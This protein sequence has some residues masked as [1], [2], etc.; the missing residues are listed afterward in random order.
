MVW[1]LDVLLALACLGAFLVGIVL[2]LSFFRARR[3]NCPNHVLFHSHEGFHVAPTRLR[4][5]QFARRLQETHPAYRCDVL[6]YWDHIFKFPGLPDRHPFKVE[7]AAAIIR[8]FFRMW[9]HRIGLVIDQR[10]NYHTWAT[11]LY[12]LASGATVWLDIDDWIFEHYAYLPPLRIRWLLP[13]FCHLADGC[14]VASTPI[15]KLIERYFPA[16]LL[17]PTFVDER[18]F[19]DRSFPSESAVIRFAWI[20]TVFDEDS[21][22]NV[23]FVLQSFQAALPQI[24]HPVVLECL[25]GYNP[26]GTIG[27]DQMQEML[28][29]QFPTLPVRIGDWIQPDAVPAYL[30]T[31]HVGLYALVNPNDFQRSKSPT[32]LFEYMAAGRPVIATAVGEAPCFIRH[33]LDGFVAHSADEFRDAIIRFAND[34][35]AIAAMG[36]QARQ[37]IEAEFN[38]GRVAE[39]LNANLLNRTGIPSPTTGR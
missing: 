6:A 36:V 23:R 16:P 10:P 7:L 33:G 20:G 22:T 12:R 11:V 26:L 3:R 8:S 30:G 18:L 9:T 35:G 38:L 5:Y 21:L 17:I 29:A 4:C 1:P 2:P 15:Q 14:I 31:I 13:I 19:T 37:R 27:R 39:L 25:I 24:H 32:K 28:A 34:P